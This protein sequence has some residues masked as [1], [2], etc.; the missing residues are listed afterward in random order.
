MLHADILCFTWATGMEETPC[1]YC[2]FPSSQF[3]QS[4]PDNIY[5]SENL[6]ELESMPEDG[7]A[8]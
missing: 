4:A 7:E 1:S 2:T 3:C 8:K 5:K 6:T